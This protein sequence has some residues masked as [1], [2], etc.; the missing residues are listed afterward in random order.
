[1]EKKVYKI[2]QYDHVLKEYRTLLVVPRRPDGSRF[3]LYML[4]DSEP[5]KY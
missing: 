1:M 3:N 2:G 4:E 5:I